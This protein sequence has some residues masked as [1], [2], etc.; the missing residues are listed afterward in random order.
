MKAASEQLGMCFPSILHFT[1]L[2]H[3]QIFTPKFLNT[4]LRFF[5]FSLGKLVHGQLNIVAH[6]PVA[7]LMNRMKDFVKLSDSDRYFF[8]NRSFPSLLSF[9]SRGEKI[10][11]K[12]SGAEAIEASIKLARHATGKTNIITFEGSF[13]GRTIGT[14]SLTNSK[15]IYR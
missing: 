1:S 5:S 7:A 6:K 11:L 8:S 4:D 3:V 9:P 2:H 10:T 14:M 15:T 13:H 12:N